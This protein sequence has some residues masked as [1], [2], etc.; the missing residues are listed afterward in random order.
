[1]VIELRQL[2]IDV[3][4]VFDRVKLAISLILR[5]PWLEFGVSVPQCKRLADVVG[6]EVIA[7][8]VV[9]R[10]QVGLR[11]VD[12]VAWDGPGAWI[13]KGLVRVIKPI[14]LP[15]SEEDSQVAINIAVIYL[16]EPSAELESPQLTND[17]ARR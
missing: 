15:K 12:R 3:S 17:A 14:V 11:R 2:L 10:R 9:K 6:L 8:L 4:F 7:I 1:M 13:S 16:L 5:V